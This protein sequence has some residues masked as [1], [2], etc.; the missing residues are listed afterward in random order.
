MDNVIE[1]NNLKKYFGDVKAVDDISFTVK[2]G[3]LFAFLGLNGAGKSTTIN[4]ICGVLKKDSGHCFINNQSIEEIKNILPD[5]GIV[6]QSSVLDKKLTVY[7]NLFFRAML[8]GLKKDE[9]HRNLK[10]FSD[11]LNLKDIMLK[12][13]EKLSGGQKRKIDIVRALIHKPDILILDEPTTGLDPQTRVAVWKL[14]DELRAKE[15]LSVLL[16]TH[17]MEEAVEADYV[18]IMDGG[19]IAAKGTPVDLKNRYA[20]DYVYLYEYDNS[21]LDRLKR[22]NIQFEK[23]KKYLKLSFNDIQSAKSF[24]LDNYRSINDMEIIKG[25]MDDVFLNITGK[26]LKE[27]L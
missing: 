22:A 10:F 13:F 7:D 4:I 5:L 20:K 23:N 1:I 15:G 25:R 2:K 11:R 17:Y 12:P 9:F 3:E 27:S 19:K 14:I 24:V 6:F 26:N 21:L 18:V 8:Y 16:T